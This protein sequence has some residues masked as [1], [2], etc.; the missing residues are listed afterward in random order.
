MSCVLEKERHAV[1]LAMKRDDGAGASVGPDVFEDAVR[2]VNAAPPR[3]R[4]LEVV[5]EGVDLALD[6]RQRR[7]VEIGDRDGLG[8]AYGLAQPARL[9]PLRDRSPHSNAIITDR[10]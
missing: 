9:E 2:V 6:A 4:C 8:F 5:F 10:S 7:L 1:R 3:E